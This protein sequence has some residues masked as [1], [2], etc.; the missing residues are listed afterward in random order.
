MVIIFS[1][2]VTENAI[3]TPTNQLKML[4]IS[5]GLLREII[6]N[7]NGT[8]TKNPYHISSKEL[9]NIINIMWCLYLSMCETH[10]LKT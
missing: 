3:F 4:A 6:D 10:K 9:L 7:A 8:Q 5:E 1:L 2:V